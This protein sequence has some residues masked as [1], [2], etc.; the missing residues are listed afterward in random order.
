MQPQQFDLIKPTEENHY[1]VFSSDLEHD[2]KIFFHVTQAINFNKIIK[3]GFQSAK[4]L[5]VGV[6]ESVSYA[7][8]SSSCLAHLGCEVDENLVIF[9]VCFTE[10]QLKHVTCN[11]SDIHVHKKKIQPTIVG[12]VCIPEGYLII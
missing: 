2:P 5:G 6:L 7:R 11:P 12:Y 3:S 10:E 8:H 1:C 9:A 4:Q